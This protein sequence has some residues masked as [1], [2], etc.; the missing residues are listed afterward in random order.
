M[1]TWQM[2]VVL[3]LIWKLASSIQFFSWKGFSQVVLL[4]DVHIIDAL[5]A[6]VNRCF[7]RFIYLFLVINLN[8]KTAT[9]SM[10]NRPRRAVV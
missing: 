9:A 1:L 2:I 8:R 4:L 7:E 6:D 5:F 10:R 3:I